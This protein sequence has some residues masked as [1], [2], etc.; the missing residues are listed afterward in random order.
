MSRNN[1]H[2]NKRNKWRDMRSPLIETPFPDYYSREAVG[3]ANSRDQ[4]ANLETNARA[5]DNTV[6]SSG[7]WLS[8]PLPQ[9]EPEEMYVMKLA[10]RRAK[11]PKLVATLNLLASFNLVAFS[12]VPFAMAQSGIIANLC[13]LSLAATLARFSMDVLCS[14]ARRADRTSY[15]EVAF[16]SFGL[17]GAYLSTVMLLTLT[18]L[19]VVA[20]EKILRDIVASL[21]EYTLARA[22]SHREGDILLGACL[23]VLLPICLVKSLSA[24]QYTNYVGVAAVVLSVVVVAKRSIDF[25][26]QYAYAQESLVLLPTRFSDMLAS[27]PIYIMA[28][29]CQFNLLSVYGDNQ[30]T[31]E[32]MK[33]AISTAVSAGSFLYMLF[34]LF[35]Y[36]F[37]YKRTEGNIFLNF[38]SSDPLLALARVCFVVTIFMALPMMVLPCRDALV[39]LVL[40]VV[41]MV[42]YCAQFLR[43]RYVV[44]R[45][46]GGE[47]ELSKP[48]WD[49]VSQHILPTI[50]EDTELELIAEHL[51]LD[52]GGGA[53]GVNKWVLRILHFAFTPIV[54]F[55][56]GIMA[57]HINDVYGVW[58]IAGSTISLLVA[59]AGPCLMYLRLR[60]PTWELLTFRRVTGVDIGCLFLILAVFVGVVVLCKENFST[61]FCTE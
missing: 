49:H 24:L 36:T 59:Y 17:T 12:A 39:K 21:A 38:Q 42:A 25:N 32:R 13:I 3:N 52:G 51:S 2:R 34:G 53:S 41:H 9:V 20:Y 18:C 19:L 45:G 43:Y 54:L 47:P 33:G 14:A 61:W 50:D 35:G 48:E 28:F 57:I 44:A 46:K 4:S 56:C 23:V 5:G 7:Q 60:Y 58:L 37:A 40:D 8:V 1:S 15:V 16:V 30:L 55:G 26:S 22:I 31:K 11:I 29:L 27:V 10:E 6:L